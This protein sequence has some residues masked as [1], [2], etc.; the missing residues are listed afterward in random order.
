MRIIRNLAT[1][2]EAAKGAILALGNF[3]GLHR[4]HMAVLHEAKR[5]AHKYNAPLAVMSFEP[6]PR[7]FFNPSL[8]SLRL[9]PLA[10]KLRRL[11]AFGVDYSFL[12]RFTR[13]FSQHSAQQF[14]EN[15][16]V[17]QLAIRGLVTG[18]KFIF[19]HQRS[20]DT[21]FLQQAAQQYGFHYTAHQREMLGSAACSSTRIR[22][23]ISLG[24]MEQAARL[25]GQP[26]A[27]TGQIIHGDKRG[28]E[29]GFP[30]ANLR[31]SP[32]FHPAYGVYVVRLHDA[33]G[34]AYNGVANFGVRPMY[35]LPTPMLESYLF[36]VDVN[37]YGQKVRVELLHYLRAEAKFSSKE[38]LIAQMEQD[39]SQARQWLEATS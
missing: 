29:L 23:A 25:I 3:D 20:G 30:T 10:E 13:E 24:D 12:M 38:A 37:L 28:R 33:A 34:K 35:E 14:V 39:T 15:L 5:L 9:L 1:M 16:L 18:E 36:D 4:G 8:P 27:I 6:H 21:A 11:R 19:G 31:P 22:E 7:R 26:Y 2:P 32:L 17:N